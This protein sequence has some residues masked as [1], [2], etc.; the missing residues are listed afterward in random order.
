MKAI[1]INGNWEL[2]QTLP[3]VWNNKQPYNAIEEGFKDVIRPTITN[4][5]RLGMLIYDELN[6][7]LTYQVI[8]KTEEEIFAEDLANATEV[9]SI[10][11]LVQLE[12][13][14]VTEDGILAIIDTL[15]EP[16]KTIAKVSFK[17]AT[18]FERSNPLLALVGQAYGFDDDKLDEIFVNANKLPI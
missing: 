11:F 7:V 16:N 17:R 4:T 2:F 10:N 13:E 3:K 12:L 9:K 5:Q 1:H 8:D 14:G 6:D 18:F 15:P